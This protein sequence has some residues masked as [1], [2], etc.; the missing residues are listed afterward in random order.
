MATKVSEAVRF[1]PKT[2]SW[3]TS[4]GWLRE[5]GGSLIETPHDDAASVEVDVCPAP[6]LA[7]SAPHAVAETTTA[8]NAKHVA[9]LIGLGEILLPARR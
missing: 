3:R 9:A 6:G 1:S 7:R 2:R 4:S 5:R 8:T